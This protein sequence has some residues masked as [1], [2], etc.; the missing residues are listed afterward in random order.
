[1]VQERTAD[2]EQT[3][4]RLQESVRE[5]AA[6]LSE[7]SVQEERNRISQEIHDQVGHTLT[8]SIVQLE[9][10][11]MLLE[12]GDQRGLE[13]LGLSQKLVRK[14]LDDIRE[15][16][17]M[18]KQ[19][20][21][22]FKLESAMILLM[23]QTMEATGIII[24]YSFTPLPQLTSM[25]K[26]A[27]YHALQEGLTNGIRHGHS[28]RFRFQLAYTDNKLSFTLWNNGLSYKPSEL[29]FGLETMQERVIQLGGT[30]QL[31]TA[32]AEG[33]GC[34]LWIELPIG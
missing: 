7:L 13:K 19:Q 17:R 34:L 4:Q 21:A 27:L 14:G 2:L 15:S 22:D 23:N 31:K 32:S 30:L 8:T 25:H 1:M 3:T 26:K 28:T 16:V 29:G 6:T 33:D 20:G 12:R 11:R 18:M 9:A 5:T 10:A 24:D